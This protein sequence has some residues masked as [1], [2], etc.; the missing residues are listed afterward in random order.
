MRRLRSCLASVA[1]LV[2]TGCGRP[3]PSSGS[4]DR[5]GDPPPG[6]AS[7]SG[8]AG[9][10]GGG[11]ADPLPALVV[12]LS[13]QVLYVSADGTS[14][15]TVY[16]FARPD[17]PVGSLGGGWVM[18][19]ARGPHV[20]ASISVNAFDGAAGWQQGDRA[21]LLDDSAGVLWEKAFVTGDLGPSHARAFSGRL[22]EGGN[23]VLT[24]GGRVIFVA[25]DGGE[26]PLDGIRTAFPPGPGPIV[27]VVLDAPTLAGSTF[28]W[29]RPEQAAIFIGYP[30]Y[31]LL[32]VATVESRL[33]FE[34]RD[35]GE[36]RVLVDA[37]PS[38]F[39][40]RPWPPEA[41]DVAASFGSG[42]W[43]GYD[44]GTEVLRFNALTGQVANLSWALPEGMRRLAGPWFDADGSL[45]VVLRDDYR[46]GVYRSA[47]AGPDWVQI[48]KTLG[49]VETV[50]VGQVAGSYVI[51]ATGTD[52][53]FVPKQSWLPAPA[54]QE[55]ALQ[56]RSHQIVRPADGI[57][58]EPALALWSV[59]LSPDGLRALYWRSAE[60]GYMLVMHD[61]ATGTEQQIAFSSY[62][63]A[64][65][66]AW[67]R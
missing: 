48:G 67:N 53:W 20:L 26:H 18:V 36:A 47:A 64:Y 61:L 13:D 34:S 29:W 66:S 21:V 59:Q 49:D 33:V 43:Q 28:G 54:G 44:R 24:V 7:D 14:V 5:G 62:P 15:R 2:A 60:P 1:L 17:I 38:G 27:P 50:V 32:H 19:D 56:G 52:D 65:R 23:A 6:E 11:T 55:P 31:L 57:A 22:G 41:G 51:E 35:A 4:S 10:R 9:G 45:I 40:T 37:R 58:F 25:P 39:E 3:L 8:A 46:A 63:G 42:E 12:A 16:R 30:I